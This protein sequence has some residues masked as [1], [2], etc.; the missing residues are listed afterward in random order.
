M[1]GI[2][3]AGTESYSIT[4]EEDSG[5]TYCEE[6]VYFAERAGSLLPLIHPE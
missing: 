1:T 6:D 2:R 4:Y 3:F 5:N